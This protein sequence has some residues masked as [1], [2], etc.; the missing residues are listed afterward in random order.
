MKLDGLKLIT[1][2]V[3]HDHRGFFLESFKASLF[4]V[5][6]VQDNH[7]YS[8]KDVLRGMHFQQGQ[9][10]LVRV[11]YGRIFDVAVDIRPS[12]PTFG[13]WEGVY[14]DDVTH[15]QLYI[16]PGFAHGFCVMS[17]E[18]HVLY[19][20][21]MEYDPELEKGFHYADPGV[22]IKWPINNPILS[23]RDQQH[24]TMDHWQK[25]HAR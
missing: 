22:G 6:F 4:D 21:T 16:P 14:L 9:G 7:S 13:A 3:Y 25:G 10:K 19:K 8:K 23:E 5:D 18:A 12:S 2:K 1:P 24:E 11:G 20:V 15:Q 17:S